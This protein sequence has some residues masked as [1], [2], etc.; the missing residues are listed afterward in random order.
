VIVLAL[1]FV[2]KYEKIDCCN[3]YARKH[4]GATVRHFPLNRLAVPAG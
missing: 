4:P 1:R 2:L 3:Y